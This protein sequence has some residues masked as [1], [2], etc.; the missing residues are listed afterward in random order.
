MVI[1]RAAHGSHSCI[2]LG[3]G[4]SS[5][6]Q[7]RERSL[8]PASPHR[9]SASL[10]SSR[11]HYGFWK[12]SKNSKGPLSRAEG[13]ANS[14]QQLLGIRAKTTWVQMLHFQAGPRLQD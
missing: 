10:P 11:L 4:V 7:V 8:C 3:S 1:M 2:N 9:V 6:V 13:R 14:K 5:L 12:T